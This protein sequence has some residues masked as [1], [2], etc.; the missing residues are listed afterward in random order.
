[1]CRHKLR[2]ALS[3]AQVRHLID[4]GIRIAKASNGVSV[5]T[6]PAPN[7]AE[8]WCSIATRRWW[9]ARDSPRAEF[10]PKDDSA[11][12][13]QIDVEPAMLSL[14]FPV[15]VNLHGAAAETLKLRRIRA[16]PL[17]AHKLGCCS[18]NEHILSP[19]AEFA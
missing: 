8:T 1:M 2:P 10:L 11:K 7:R 6:L 4:R 12:A 14:R 18:F 15:D 13:A 5:L 17:S 3:L 19:W 9:L 16:G